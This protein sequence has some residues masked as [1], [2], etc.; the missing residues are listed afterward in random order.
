MYRKFF[1]A[2]VYAV[3]SSA[4]SAELLVGGKPPELRLEGD[5]GGLLDDSAW[6]SASLIGRVHLLMY[7]DPDESKL[8]ARVEEMLAAQKYDPTQV[9]SVGVVN[10]AATWKPGFAIDMILKSKQEK[11]PNTIYLRDKAKVF[12]KQWGLTDDSY[13]VVALGREG[14]VLFSAGGKLSD[15]QITTLIEAIDGEIGR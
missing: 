7:V 6:S 11:F 4:A 14:Q 5:S 13:H 2:L 12:V 10:M 9:G 15:S 1:L 8:N 3:V